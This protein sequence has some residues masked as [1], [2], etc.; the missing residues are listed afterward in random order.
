MRLGTSIAGL[1]A[2]A[3]LAALALPWLYALG[4]AADQPPAALKGVA[5]V[6][7]NGDY[8]H[9]ARLDNPAN[10]ARAVE[11]LL[12]ELG[13]ET[14]VVADRDARRL[15]RAL[16]GFAED[17]EGA[18]VA[19][20]Y[21]SGHGI[22]A[23][24]ENYLVPV[25]A[26]LSALDDAG[27][28]LVPLS[29][30]VDELQRTVPVTIVMLDACRSNPFPPGAVVKAEPSAAG[31]PVGSG[32]LGAARGAV[33]LTATSKRPENFGT[34]IG[35]AAEPG[36]VALDGAPGTN[37]PYAAA[38]LR[39][40]GAMEGAEFGVVMRMVAEEVY[41][42]TGGR[43]RPWVNESLS[44]LLYFGTPAPEPE[45]AEGD[46]LHERRSLLLTIAALPESGR[47]QIETIAGAGGVPMDALYAMLAALGVDRPR[48]PGELDGLL[49]AQTDRLKAMLAERDA[50]KS[51][52]P[53][54]KRLTGLADQAIG[55]G[56][57]ETAVRL[58]GEA[59]ARVDQ[60]GKAVDDAE[61]DI[62]R[63]RTEFASVYA[64][65]GQAHALKFDFAA[66][67]DDFGEAYRQVARWDDRLAWTYKQDE[68]EALERQGTLSGDNAALQASVAA[69]GEALRIAGPFAERTSWARSQNLLGN[70]LQ[71][72]GDRGAGADY[73]DRSV[74]AYKAALAVVG[75]TADPGFVA[76]AKNNLANTLTMIGTR[77][78][79]AALLRQAVELYQPA[80]DR[81]E[82]EQDV[83]LWASAYT[84]FGKT[85]LAL[86][87][88]ENSA[89][90]LNMAGRAFEAALSVTDREQAPL[91]WGAAQN[92]IGNVYHALGLRSLDAN[93]SAGRH[94]QSVVAYTMAMQE[95]TR[96]KVP[97]QWAATQNNLA[98][99]YQALAY[100]QRD[101]AQSMSYLNQSADAQRAA[102]TEMTQER[103][104]LMWASVKT[105]LGRTLMMIGQAARTPAEG[106]PR[107]AEAVAAA[108]EALQ[109]LTV[110]K[111]PSQFAAAQVTLGQAL[112]LT[113]Q[114]SAG[115]EAKSQAL[116]AAE[117]AQRAALDIYGTDRPFDRA[118]AQHDLGLT[119]MMQGEAQPER[120]AQAEDVYR[121][122]Q[123]LRDR[124][125][126]PVGWARAEAGIANAL[127]ARGT[128]QRDRAVLEEARR[129]TQSAWDTI[130]PIDSQYD[131]ILAERI[132]AIDEALGSL[133]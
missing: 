127:Q 129:R 24:G 33:S 65:S 39:H 44:R 31:A 8:E 102:L 86:G 1:M 23:G 125:H 101:P 47:R 11:Q 106:L 93:V 91:I 97:L 5:L 26:D 46:I 34:V 42:K 128:A 28:K 99:A 118:S 124:A 70:A 77:D 7:G 57:L 10:D 53:E 95:L 121:A 119:L 51:E 73:L 89:D 52:D 63:K 55:E 25:D 114:A 92:N 122:E 132:A 133:R 110:Q 13:F 72:L 19:I 16:E 104:P 98:N 103:A 79:D 80:I 112:Q 69:A 62:A 45:G 131:G 14:D 41:L 109:V 76:K 66:A 54:I 21:Y 84:N 58:L 22:E 38:I 64:R 30:I 113:A 2:R 83:Q 67:A 15:R 9:I 105:N 120:Y 123:A 37:S 49:R 60:L 4:M 50:L 87:E 59:K 29:E 27:E 12:D 100:R 36:Q 96:D 6:I 117:A 94:L 85:L 3:L 75:E 61:A 71:T 90:T 78:G 43:Q 18:D 68:A 56:A 82:V 108:R 115:A 74:D 35:F 17:A 88:I 116:A 40:L 81:F 126:D 48:D 107:F 20:I 111:F 130:R 32:G